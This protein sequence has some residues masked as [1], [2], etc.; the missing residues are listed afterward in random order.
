MSWRGGNGACGEVRR[1]WRRQAQARISWGG[2]DRARGVVLHRWMRGA[3]TT[4][5]TSVCCN[6]VDADGVAGGRRGG[7]SQVELVERDLCYRGRGLRWRRVRAGAKSGSLVAR[8]SLVRLV[9]RVM[10]DVAM[11]AMASSGDEGGPMRAGA[12]VGGGDALVEGV[13]GGAALAMWRRR[14]VAMKA[15]LDG[16]VV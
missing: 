11:Q 14:S 10:A 16:V 7:S 8:G 9:A 5:G 12:R 1:R 4:I 15:G 13:L 6:G 3:R 2:G